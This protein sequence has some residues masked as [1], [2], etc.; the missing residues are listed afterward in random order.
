MALQV[1]ESDSFMENQ[2]FNSSFIIRQEYKE[3][4]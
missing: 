2:T 1:I 4:T 3:V